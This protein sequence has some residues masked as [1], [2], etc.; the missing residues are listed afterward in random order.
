MGS[1]ADRASGY[2]LYC[3]W[4]KSKVGIWILH[5][6]PG[7]RNDWVPKTQTA[8]VW[9]EGRSFGDRLLDLGDQGLQ[10]RA[11]AGPGSIPQLWSGVEVKFYSTSYKLTLKQ[12]VDGGLEHAALWPS[13]NAVAVFSKR[14]QPLCQGSTT[15]FLWT[16]LGLPR[17]LV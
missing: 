1:W 2:V 10:L 15:G 9:F 17:D 7:Y 16:W 14:P 8:E 6:L 13:K 3:Q 11:T 4:Q 12:I 5:Q